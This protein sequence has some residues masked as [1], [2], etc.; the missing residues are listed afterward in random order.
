MAGFDDMSGIGHRRPSTR[1]LM[2]ASASR[3]L[4]TP[5]W[6]ANISAKRVAANRKS[7]ALTRGS[8]ST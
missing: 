1:G 2:V 3:E 4:V 5:G 6:C 7:G 8:S